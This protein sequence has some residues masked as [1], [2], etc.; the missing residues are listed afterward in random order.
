MAQK[1]S[2]TTP[3]SIGVS[4]TGTGTAYYGNRNEPPRAMVF[5]TGT[6]TA[7]SFLANINQYFGIPAEFTFV[8]AESNTD[9]LGMRHRLLQQYYKGI[10]VEGMGYR[11]H[12]KGGFVTS[13]NGKAVRNMSPDMHVSLSEE[14]A[15]QLAARSVQT[16]DTTV[17][18]GQKLIVS[19]GFT[20]APESF[21]I[22]FQ[23]DIDVSLIERWRISIDARNGQMINKV[24]LV[25]TCREEEDA[26]PLPYV[27]GSGTTSYYGVKPIR[28][29]STGSGSQMVGQ[30]AHGGIIGTYDF[31]NRPVIILQLGIPF[32]PPAFTS[33]GTVYNDNYYQPAVSAQWAAE[34]AY[35]YYYQKHNRNSFD[36]NGGAIKSYV[37]VDVGWDN[38]MWTG[39]LLALGDGSNNN[40]LVELDVVSHELTHGVTQYEAQLQYYYESGALNESFSD[41][42]GK[43]VEFDVF[44]GAATWQIGRH[45]QDGGIRDMSNPNLKTQPDTY[46][47]D[48][49]QTSAEDNGGVHTNSGVQNFWFYLLCKG[50]SGVNDHQVNYA[51][52]PIGMDAAVKIAY[53]NLTEYLGPQ[54]DYLD[55]RIGSLLATADL[56]GNNSTTYQE[57]VNAWDAVGVIDEPTITSLDVYDITAT[58]VK[59]TG[60]MIPKSTVASYHFEYGTTPAYGSSTATYPYTDKIEG[61]ITG[62]QSQTKYYL[63]LVATNENGNSYA[64]R[65]FTTISLAPMVRLK[66]M[67]DVTETN[68]TLY[69]QINPN[70]L[71]T[72]FYFEYGLTPA[73]GSATP[74]YPLPAATEFQD[75]SATIAN[76]QPLQTY[77]Y[78]LVA[79]NGFATIST[80]A[81][82]FFTAVKPVISSMTPTKGPIGT[83][84]TITGQHFN[85]TP[86][87]NFVSFGATRGTVLSSTSTQIK[88]TVPAG[89]SLGPIS[90]LDA[91]SGLVGESVREFVPTFTAE[92]KKSDVLLTV[93]ST[94]YIY[95]TL[96]QDMDGDGKPDIIARHY[97]GF[98]VFQNV[99]QGGD[100][101][102]A[103]FV[104]NIFP[105]SYTPG[106]LS[107]VDFDG[108]GLKDIAEMYQGVLHI[109]PNLS[110]PGFIFFGVP[111]SLDMSAVYVLDYAFNDFD[112]DGHV[113][114]AL[115][116]YSSYTNR[117]WIEI[118]QN[119]NPKG[120]L[121]AE[122][123]VSQYEKDMSSYMYILNSDDLNNDGK[124]DLLPSIFDLNAAPIV[125]NN[126]QPGTWTF[127]NENNIPN[128]TTVRLP[129]YV[130]RDLNGDGWRDIIA[131]SHD[132]AGNVDILE[133]KETSPGITMGKTTLTSGSIASVIQP[134][135]IDGDGAVDL[136]IGLN[137]GKFAFMKNKGAANDPISNASF[138][139]FSEHGLP[140]SSN[141]TQSTMTIND[142]NGD[143]RPDI[144]NT[145]SYNS[146][147][148]D[149]YMME[150]WQNGPANCLD[151]SG[152]SVSVSSYTATIVLP[153][154]TTQDQFE[155]DYTTS[156]G[157]Y[158]TPTYGLT[159]YVSYGNTYQLRV[160]AK[161]YQG[162]TDY[163]YIDF[164][165]DCVDTSSFNVSSIGIDNVSLSAY[166]LSSFEVQY[167]VAG[168]N[169]WI[170]QSQYSNQITNLLP[171]TLYDIRFRGRCST[172][173]EFKYKQFTTLCGKLTRI[174]VTPLLDNTADVRWTTAYEGNVVL[175]YSLDNFNWTLIDETLTIRSLIPGKQYVVRGRMACTNANS[176]FISTSFTAPCP[177]VST[178]YVD[179]VTPFS[180]MVNWVDAS[181]T[182]NYVLTYAANGGPVTTRETHSTA[183]NLQGLTPG[184][185][186]TV[187]VAPQCAT[188]N[189]TLATFNTICYVPFNLSADAITHT[190]A[191][192]SWD[193]NFDGFPYT[194]EYSISGSNVWQTTE[195]AS[196]TISL[197]GLRPGAKY[198]VRVHIP[199]SSE[200]LAYASLL[201]ETKLYN[202]TTYFPNPTD[203]E[204]TIHPSRDL[205]GH[206]FNIYDNVGNSVANGELPDYTID[207]SILAPGVYVLRIDGES[208]MKIVKR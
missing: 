6:V 160:R 3:A 202:E 164:Q 205:I 46:V 38:A 19:K 106:T 158:W 29:E 175:E 120:F 43:A 124:P 81:A 13:V 171:G 12:E 100:I 112:Q 31:G 143:G 94:D 204:I 74:T 153:P 14:Q 34:Q 149:G 185:S 129:T 1:S 128:N 157:T 69:G 176:D 111:V 182:G 192:L 52:N 195:T 105:S 64:T 103:S 98:S 11:L 57:V 154:N 116:R 166:S 172:P 80:P 97:L 109:Y 123:F 96:V 47:G 87:N 118:L 16:K 21:A 134:A 201:F 117:N 54:S 99:N 92:F 91:Q 30:T 61:I 108:N 110:V 95:Q 184:T 41:I 24:S 36:N 188:K 163:Y 122:N 159:I 138:E 17:R 207:L 40:P 139:K 35:E 181:G 194:I 33:S 9:D 127:V 53:R 37:H 165:P 89:A 71:A 27:T 77:H 150:I 137:N 56:Y 4:N 170:L 60:S 115:S 58:T 82:T 198:E 8:E 5:K 187:S 104:R 145:H 75:I 119:K 79:T 151:P 144:I 23:F 70:S 126:S 93:G 18:K 125:R 180:A 63:K 76:L 107:L 121:L 148:H 177:K 39:R 55:S 133:N 200:T 173:S 113:D 203:G 72:S 162:F 189:F 42:L 26:P 155:I 147:P 66:Q 132:Q 85:P 51:V 62:L 197:T 28:I 168:Q 68:A 44:G 2:R 179:A 83:E 206:R 142:L 84:I 7:S 196:T 178:L 65:E 45:F 136:V 131:Y 190:T 49:W 102:E 32:T 73:F 22:A 10:P 174:T 20:L 25:N 208:P 86:K 88:V 141:S 191:D 90:V 59:I 15:F 167:S 140:I 114:I 183:F 48:M 193:D 135:D 78:R 50:G 199:C 169:Q 101:T 186:Y 146:F 67:V 152:V 156:G 161:C 130:T